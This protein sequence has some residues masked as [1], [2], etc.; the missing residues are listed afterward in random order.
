MLTILAVSV[1]NCLMICIFHLHR[2]QGEPSKED[3][4]CNER[5]TDS[6]DKIFT[7]RKLKSWNLEGGLVDIQS[8]KKAAALEDYPSP[9]LANEIFP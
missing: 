9:R 4:I 3:T 1:Y 6:L 8:E 5:T 2:N 7:E